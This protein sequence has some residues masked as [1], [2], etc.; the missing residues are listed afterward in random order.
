MRHPSFTGTVMQ[1]AAT[2]RTVLFQNH[3][4]VLKAMTVLSQ[5]ESYP[6]AYGC[7]A[8]KD[9]TGLLAQLVLSALG[10]SREDIIADYMATNHSASHIASCVDVCIAMWGEELK[11]T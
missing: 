3:D 5:P 4:E 8:G 9:R 11:T 2:M 6:I 1:L 10:V 7:M